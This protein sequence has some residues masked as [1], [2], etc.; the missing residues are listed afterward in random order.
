MDIEISPRHDELIRAAYDL[1]DRM[2]GISRDERVIIE[3]A[4]MMLEFLDEYA[5][6]VSFGEWP[7][8]KLD[9]LTQRVNA[10]KRTSNI[11][12]PRNQSQPLI[13][14]GLFTSP[15]P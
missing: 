10:P 12:C 11:P 3:M 15:Q 9:E 6:E 8:E 14:P 13:S 4:I 1:R 7:L 2:Q 5:A